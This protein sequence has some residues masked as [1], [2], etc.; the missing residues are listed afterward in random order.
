MKRYLTEFLGTFFLVLTIGL[1]V[2]GGVAMAPLAIGFTI[3]AAAFAGGSIS[4]GAFNPAVG[5]GPIIVDSMHGGKSMGSAWIYLVGP[6]S[7]GALA[8]LVYFIQHCGGKT[9]DK[10]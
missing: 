3:T 6:F 9:P 10:P 7:G 8:A 1:T 4:G 5:L 2:T